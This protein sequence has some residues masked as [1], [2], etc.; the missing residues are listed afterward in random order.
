MYELYNAGAFGNK[1][2]TWANLDEFRASGYSGR[3][4]LRYKGADAARWCK[5]FVATGEIDAIV[6]RWV[7]E[8]ADR[9][10]VTVGMVDDLNMITL[11][12]EVQRG[13]FGYDL[14]YSFEFLPMRDALAKSQFHASGLKALAILRH[15]LDPSS[16]ADLEAIFEK[17]PDSVA[18]FTTYRVNVGEIPNRNTVVWEVRNY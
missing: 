1:F 12:G 11:Q 6:D 7:S 5:P 13:L 2:K 10:R 16:F 4:T 17:W 3:I 8:G 9:S 14:R 15:Y 18:E